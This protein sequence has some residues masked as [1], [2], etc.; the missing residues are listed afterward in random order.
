MALVGT[1][2]SDVA[3]DAVYEAACRADPRWRSRFLVID[4]ADEHASSVLAE[5]MHVP[6]W[7]KYDPVAT[8]GARLASFGARS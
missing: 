6:V 4:E 3:C 7:S 8:L 2:V 5:L 1:S